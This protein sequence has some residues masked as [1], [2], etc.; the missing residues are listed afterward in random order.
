MTTKNELKSKKISVPCLSTLTFPVTEMVPSKDVSTYEYEKYICNITNVK[1]ML[2][3]YGVAII[4]NLINSKECDQM[5]TGMWDYLETVTANLPVPMKKSDHKTWSS[6]KHLY[7]KHSMLIQNWSIGHAQFIWKLRT[8]PKIMKVFSKLWSCDPEDLLVSFDGASFHF[9]PEIT[10][11]GWVDESKTWLHSDQSYYKP[12]FS[13]VQSWINAYDTN[14]GDATLT[15][16]EG[17]N[18]FHQEFA[19][20]FKP[21]NRT[22]WNLLEKRELDWYEKT[23]GCA[24]VNIKC[25]AGSLVLWDS[26]TIHC[27]T[28]PNKSRTKS[29]YRCC[30]YLCYTPRSMAT[31]A[32]LSKKIKAWKDLRTTS[33]WPHRPNLFPKYPHTWGTPLPPIVPISKPDIPD[34]GYRLIG[35]VTKPGLAD[36]TEISEKT[37]ILNKTKTSKNKTKKEHEIEV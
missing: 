18:R 9:P 32:I 4:P 27:G 6:F 15:V 8:N 28:E 21:E 3:A 24:R 34:I 20:T 11:F 13:C 14:D 19:N 5:K 35:Y 26:R 25:P 7:P 31:E 16:L 12:G 33:H 36:K 17:S 30:V 22:D 23:K 10:G 29:N 2:D 37:N 1:Q